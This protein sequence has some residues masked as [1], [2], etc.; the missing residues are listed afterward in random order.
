MAT[1]KAQ[2][3]GGR[4]SALKQRAG[5]LLNYYRNPKHCK[6]CGEIIKVTDSQK[7]SE[8]KKKNY[9]GHSCAAKAR[10]AE[11][12]R[13]K[14]GHPCLRCNSMVY[15]NRTHGGNH[16]RSKYCRACCSLKKDLRDLSR[17]TKGEVF[18]ACK[19]WQSARSTIC[20]H[21][22]KMYMRSDEPK[23]CANCG[24]MLHVEVAHRIGVSE[25]SNET[26]ISIINHL[27]NLMALCPTHH[28]E[29]EHGVLKVNRGK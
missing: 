5:A 7:V 22:R 14:K 3:L 8:V 16:W 25:F 13:E 15:S 20:R 29:Q 23:I 11:F 2:R 6:W 19:N 18:K 28:W 26:L 12:V 27:E 21:A 9:C 24:Y 4:A 10:N 1:L 17:K